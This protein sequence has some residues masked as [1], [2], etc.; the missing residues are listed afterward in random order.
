[1]RINSLNTRPPLSL[2]IRLYVYK[3]VNVPLVLAMIYA[4]L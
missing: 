4:E 2:P 3:R 1:M